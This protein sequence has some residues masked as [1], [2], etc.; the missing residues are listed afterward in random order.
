MRQFSKLPRAARN[1]VKIIEEITGVKVMKYKKYNYIIVGAGPAGLFTAIGLVK[2][3]KSKM[4]VL[5]VEQGSP[6]EERQRHETM[7]G[8]GGAGTFSDGK[9]H[10]TP[11]LSHVK[12]LDIFSLEEYQKEIDR[13][14]RWF[15]K[16][17][18][19]GEYTPKDLTKAKKLVEDC[20]K[21]GVYLYLRRCKHI[22]SDKLPKVTQNMVDF[23]KDKGVEFLCKTEVKEILVAKKMV[24]GLKTK[25]GLLKADKYIVCPGRIGA[26]WLQDQARKIGL[27]YSYQKVEV[28]VRVEFPVGIMKQHSEIMHENIYVIQTP[29]YDD[30]VRTFCP[31]PGGRVA[32]ENYSDFLS[33]N[34]HSNADRG[35]RSENSNFDL[36]TEV[37]LTDPVE[38]TMDYAI[39]VAR[40]A[41]TLGG[42]K[43]LIQRLADLRH[44]R[45]STWNRINKSYVKPTLT[46][47]TPGDISMALPHR[48]V[49][50]ILEGLERLDRVLPG[51]NA[52]ANLIY[53]PE[54]KLRGNRIKINKKMQTQIKN[55]FMA[56]DGPGTSG[57]IVGAAASGL[58]AAK[59]AMKARVKV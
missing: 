54:I 52:G 55:L 46:T 57:N 49:S 20:Q 18:A 34:G 10:F 2:R 39:S 48:T 40:L 44:G 22:G 59:G 17:G 16:F 38:N 15:T 23:L 1:Y 12:L 7:R 13:V 19:E 30:V 50:N 24:V 37:K 9:L 14:D 36:T 47:V 28:G 29:T 4:K 41:T 3:K 11:V 5:L 51:I 27:D 8:V 35:C 26:K 33:V 42:G 25:N 32:I 56:G 6:I 45:R 21:E 31:C 58:L 43:P 53:A